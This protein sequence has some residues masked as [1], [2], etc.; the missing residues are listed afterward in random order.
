LYRVAYDVP[1]KEQ[2]GRFVVQDD[3]R[4][5]ASIPT[6]QYL[7]KQRC[8]IVILTWAGRPDGKVVEKYKLDPIAKRLAVLLRHPVTKLDDCVGS[9]VTTAVAKMKP[10]EVIL[11]ENVRFH[12][13]EETKNLKFMKQLAAL[14]DIHIFDA[15]AQ[16]H[17][18]VSSIVGPQRYLPT[19]SGFTIEREIATLERMMLRPKRP[20]VAVIGGAKI[21][22]KVALVSQL[23]KKADYVLLGGMSANTI[24]QIK[25]LP[26]GR[27]RV[28]N[29]AANVARRLE[30]TNNKLKIPVDVV[31]ATRISP[32]AKTTPRAVGK[33]KSN[34]ML[35]DIG[36]DTIKLYCSIIKQARTVL[37]SGPMGYFELSPFAKGT[38]AIARAIARVKGET[39]VGGGD[40]EAAL[41]LSGVEKQIDFVSTGGGAMLEFLSG[42]SLP[43]LKYLNLPK[44]I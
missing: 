34:E 6:L 29:E 8:K 39:I 36:P 4:I 15:F 18:D 33:I 25:G 42:K 13:E 41:E 10:G 23:L 35:L 22:D 30:L 2:G 44:H 14:G 40:T 26:V 12:I 31:T 17:R 9:V 11:L 7:I 1:L 3:S 16:A 37:W 20:F 27:S 43:G 38:V 24:L 32:N 5:R 28:S 21:E 19:M